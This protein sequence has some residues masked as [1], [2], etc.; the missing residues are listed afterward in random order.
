[1]AEVRRYMFDPRAG[2]LSREEDG[3]KMMLSVVGELVPAADYNDL[4]AE[5]A[6]EKENARRGWELFETFRKKYAELRF[7]GM[8]GVVTTADRGGE[9]G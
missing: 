4:A 7:P 9:H 1:M 2:T 5:L 3:A 8:T 6:A